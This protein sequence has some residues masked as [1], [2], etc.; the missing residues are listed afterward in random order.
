MSYPA[1]CCQAGERTSQLKYFIKD[2]SQYLQGQLLFVDVILAHAGILKRLI[3]KDLFL[4]FKEYK[5]IVVTTPPLHSPSAPLLEKRRG[6]ASALTDLRFALIFSYM[7][8][9]VQIF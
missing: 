7:A 5:L 4:P 1:K 6:V 2:C 3:A 8:Y 9:M